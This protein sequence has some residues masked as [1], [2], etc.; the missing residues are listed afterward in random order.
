M[1]APEVRTTYLYVLGGLAAVLLIATATASYLNVRTLFANNA[2][3][4]RTHVVI[5]HLEQVLSALK[6]AETG[7]RGYLITGHE[8]YLEPYHNA[9]ARLPTEFHQLKA[10]MADNPLQQARIAAV[11]PQI[12]S[13]LARLEATIAQRRSNNETSASETLLKG[14][15]RKEMD[16]LRQAFA[17]M[18]NQEISLIDRRVAESEQSLWQTLFLLSL[19]LGSALALLTITGF[20]LH[21]YRAAKHE[22]SERVRAEREWLDVTLRCIGDAV[23][24][25]DVQGHIVFLN[26]V[27]E[28]LTGHDPQSAIGLHINEVFRIFNET[29][30]LPTENPV[31]RV[32]KEGIV[33][34]LA[35]HTLLIAKDGAERAIDDS[36]APIRGRDGALLGVVLV[37]RDV[38]ERR[39]AE[40]QI[41]QSWQEL[42]DFFQNTP[43]GLHW[44]GRDGII[45][46]VNQTELDLLGYAREEYVGHHISEF[47][48]SAE[49]IRDILDRLCRGE[50]L[51]NR[52]SQMR[53][54]DDLIKDV[55]ISSSTISKN[56][57]FVHT[58]CFTR[59][60][61]DRKRAEN[62][63][64]FL[65]DAGNS[66]GN[67]VDYESTLQSVARLSV[68]FFADFCVVDL[69][70]EDT[71]IRRVAAA[72]VELEKETL[73]R[74]LFRQWPLD[75]NSH[76][77][78][79][80]VLRSG[81]AEMVNDVSDSLLRDM[82]RDEAHLATLRTL[83]LRS[84]LIVPLVQRD[85]VR[86]MI[87]FV[88]SVSKRRF[89]PQDLE[90]ARALAGRVTT[91]LESARLYDE[92]REA[93]RRKDEFLAML[94]HELRNP[95]A[96]IQ[97]ANYLSSAAD[98]KQQGIDCSAMISQQLH[99]LKRLID[100]LL[101]VSR[102]T[103]NKINL[104]K[105]VLD[106][107]AVID[108]ARGVIQ[109]LIEQHKHQL[110]LE[111]PHGELLL[112]NADGA[113]LEQMIVNLLT[114]AAKYTE[115]GGQIRLLC[116][117]EDGKVLIKVRDTGIGLSPEMLSKVF[118][119]FMQV[120]GSLARS[121]GG[122][123]IGL[124]LV[125]RLA[126]LHGGGIEA[127]SQGLGK[128]SEFT[129][130]LP[131]A[132]QDRLSVSAAAPPSGQVTK[133]LRVLVVEDNVD[134][135]NCITQL[136]KN[137]GHDVQVC[138]E[139]GSALATAIEYR[140]DVVLLDLGLPGKDGYQVAA[141]IRKEK[142]LAGARLIAMSGYGQAGDRRR[143]SEA[144]FDH[145]LVKPI[146]LNTLLTVIGS[147]DGSIELPRP[148]NSAAGDGAQSKNPLAEPQEKGRIS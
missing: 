92:L 71:T 136:F 15:G 77:I 9:I 129:L 120:D 38:A 56:G 1:R 41:Q 27:A 122:L 36:A 82:A 140:P 95:L 119:L 105:E 90:L 39:R 11:E 33:V 81:Q 40:D 109:P 79:A 17:D 66:L 130:W 84:L 76:S 106:V 55:L 6:D 115:D 25:T 19:A 49:A 72:H 28:L 22:V 47:H 128:G 14:S 91:A 75:R 60:I 148:G 127:A 125:R 97:Y 50:T 13:Y 37:F 3:V 29:T 8:A 63:L 34:G 96:A 45:L 134:A 133:A 89:Q 12:H 32:L 42:E 108:R 2:L 24:A 26:P 86:G 88:Q 103:Q 121:Q 16:S 57:Q 78:I 48:V 132:V 21:V 18:E 68:P 135:A 64:R 104:K 20:L 52:E 116:C 73:L 117:R 44:I 118:S 147:V 145:H 141:G 53:S 102:I 123:G 31:L 30:R 146:D 70:V 65:A 87:T 99:Q 61:T 83:G 58:R 107:R 114:N 59:D 144:G 113:R 35:N 94:A 93:D 5:T 67:L 110:S 51:E 98:I 4:T 101:D 111:S 69:I 139:G 137:E 85:R 131:A 126:E 46:R 100:D 62:W 10:L 80:N 112:V 54:K 142:L 74:N 43:V 143:S 23:I 124:T 138:Y 7:Q